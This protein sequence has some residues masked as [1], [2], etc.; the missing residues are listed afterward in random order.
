MDKLSLFMQIL[1]S[2]KRASG[3]VFSP[4][5]LN[6]SQQNGKKYQDIL[7]MHRLISPFAML[8]LCPY[9]HQGTIRGSLYQVV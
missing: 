1:N 2:I 6:V 9:L 3:A 5:T 4:T 8:T 7:T